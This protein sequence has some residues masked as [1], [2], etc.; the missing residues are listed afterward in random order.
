MP[1]IYTA[2]TR[3]MDWQ[4]LQ[5]LNDEIILVQARALNARHCQIYR[6][7][8]DASQALLWVEL[9]DPDDVCE[10]RTSVVEQLET[11]AHVT[12]IDDRVWEPV[13][14]SP[15]VPYHTRN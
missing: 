7:P 10:M 2:I 11:L 8:N 3:V 12:L 13:S 9:P 15:A 14:F 5:K 1:V 4:A 6:D